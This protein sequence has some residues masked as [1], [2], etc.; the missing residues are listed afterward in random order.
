M[1]RPDMGQEGLGFK[2]VAW[3]VFLASSFASQ[4]HPGAWY[5]HRIAEHDLSICLNINSDH[6]GGIV[7]SYPFGKYWMRFYSYFRWRIQGMSPLYRDQSWF[8]CFLP[9]SLPSEVPTC[10]YFQI[11]FQQWSQ[12]FQVGKSTFLHLKLV[13]QEAK[14]RLKSKVMGSAH[15]KQNQ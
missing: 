7:H 6:G 14:N 10:Y 15:F 13:L 5:K 8:L 2:S 1:G 4:S 9:F 11:S 12:K 3:E